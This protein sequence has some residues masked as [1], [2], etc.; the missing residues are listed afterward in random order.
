ML[1]W[2]CCWC[3]QNTRLIVSYINPQHAYSILSE[4]WR[5]HL[6]FSLELHK[7]CVLALA[8]LHEPPYACLLFIM[9]KVLMY[10]V[11]GAQLQATYESMNEALP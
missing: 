9:S 10:F 1:A 8:S 5:Q 7:D 6:K 11:C 3:S 4:I 2:L